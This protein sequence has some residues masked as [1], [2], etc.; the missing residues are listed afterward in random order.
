MDIKNSYAFENLVAKIFSESGYTV[1]QGVQLENKT[2]DIDIIAEID[3]RKYCVEVKYSRIT[4][5]A[6]QRICD[7]AESNKM[8]PLLV[9]AYDIDEKRKEYYQKQYPD[10]IFVDI[11]NLL[12]AVQYDTELH[13]ELVASLP[14]VVDNIKPQEGFIR[15]NS[16]RHDDYTNSLIKE[17]EFC[18]A[19]KSFARTYEEICGGLL[20]NIFSEDLTLWR[21]QQKSNK[22]LYRFDLLCR[23]KDGNQ[24]TFWSIIEKYFNSKYVVF[25]FK[26]YNDPITQKEIYTTEKYLYSKALRSVGIVISAHGYDE[27]AFWAAK[28][29]LRENGKLIML[30]ETEDL[31]EMNRMKVDQEDPSNYLLDKLD[32]LLLELEK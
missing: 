4:E 21:E 3:K 28:G 13:N 14:F 10:L 9:T 18:K 19:G 12:F 15:I 11:T 29:C 7:T 5:R 24:K 20:K 30:L 25:E 17:M 27:N 26:N 22:D 31:I 32:E 6:M 23:I 1:K 2:G 8:I 16:L